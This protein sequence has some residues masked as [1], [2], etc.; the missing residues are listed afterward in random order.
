MAWA[1]PEFSKER[2][3]RAGAFLIADP[4]ELLP[5]GWFDQI[6]EALRVL[7]N[8]RSSHGYPV[9]TF[10]ATLRAKL[11]KLGVD[12]TV[13]QRL[14]RTESILHKLALNPSMSLSRMQ[15]IGGLRAVVPQLS[16]VYAL[17]ELFLNSRFD[18]VLVHQKDYI[19]EPKESG[20]RGIHLVYRY[21][22]RKGDGPTYQGLQVEIQ[23]RSKMQHSW[24]TAVETAGLFLGQALKS[25]IGNQAWL[26]FFSYA[27]SAFAIFERSA[28]FAEHAHLSH[29]EI[30]QMVDY[31]ERDLRV[32][33]CL[34]MYRVF[35]DYRDMEGKGSHYYLMRLDPK[36]QRGSVKA[37]ARA[38]LPTATEQYMQAEREA[39]GT[40]IQVVLVAAQSLESL[41]RAYPNY[42]MDTAAFVQHLRRVRRAVGVR[43]GAAAMQGLLPALQAGGL[44]GHH[45]GPQQPQPKAPPL[46]AVPPLPPLAQPPKGMQPPPPP[47]PPVK[48]PA[49]PS[50]PQPPKK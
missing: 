3:K 4:P 27:S 2:V 22:N 12:A 23:L 37:F 19:Q 45:A 13:A 5:V 8:W 36:S 6:D 44:A 11:N 34:N 7:S 39:S 31:L 16:D 49:M 10:Q 42:F 14:K 40:D 47:P 18:H 48:S 46:P 35:V 9:N 26:E 30:F 43:S 32:I 38:D 24:A 1:K 41:K 20:Y 17:R 28:V 25:S 33:D 15:D 21:N 50:P 29:S